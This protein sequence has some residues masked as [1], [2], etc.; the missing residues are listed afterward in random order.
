MDWTIFV[1]DPIAAKT[2]LL[3]TEN[4]P[5]S[6]AIFGALGDS[7]PIVKFLGNQN[8]AVS[9][10]EVWKKQRKVLLCLFILHNLPLMAFVYL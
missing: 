6:N 5:K 10:G 8:V 9:N 1:T 3:K 4:F 2:L 7:S